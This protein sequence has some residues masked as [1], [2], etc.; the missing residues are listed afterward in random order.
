[1]AQVHR[2]RSGERFAGQAVNFQMQRTLKANLVALKTLAQP[3]V[4]FGIVGLPQL[5]ADVDAVEIH[6]AV[7]ETQPRFGARVGP[8]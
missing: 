2:A 1:M 8:T 3:P 6:I 5:V 4:Q 7:A